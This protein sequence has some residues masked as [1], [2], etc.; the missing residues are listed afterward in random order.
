[1]TEEER[2]RLIEQHPIGRGLDAFRASFTAICEGL[3]AE[4]RP[5]ALAQF[6]QEGKREIWCI[7][8]I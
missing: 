7:V 2:S 6:G 8:F 3:E 1:M 4:S 5:D